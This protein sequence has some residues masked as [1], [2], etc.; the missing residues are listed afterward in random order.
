VFS[1]KEEIVELFNGQDD[2]VGNLWFIGQ[3]INV[4]YSFKQ[5]GIWQAAEAAEAGKT[6]QAPGD[7][8]IA[9]VNGRDAEGR[10]TKQ[11]DEQINADDRT[12]LGSTVPQWSGGITN[13]VSYKGFDLSVLVYARQGQLLRSDYHNV[14]AN[15][16]Q[17]RYNSLNLDYW[18]PSNPT[19]AIPLPQAGEAPLYADATRYFDG[20]FVKIKNIALGYN[21]QDKLISKLG[22]SSLRLYTTVNNA[23]TFSSFDTV[24]PETSNGTVGGDNPLTTATYIFG[25]NFQL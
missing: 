10:L 6:G 13:K 16:W 24:D 14:S 5:L 4:F 18:T 20:S 22:L 19:N 3:P 2:D 25:I 15:N 23:F 8:K 9:D 17:G 12:V 1:N 11:A 21:F 7:I